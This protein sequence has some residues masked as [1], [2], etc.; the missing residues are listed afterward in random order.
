MYRV[1]FIADSQLPKTTLEISSVLT[2]LR[3][4]SSPTAAGF[5]RCGWVSESISTQFNDFTYE[6]YRPWRRYE[7]VVFAKSF[8]GECIELALKLK[9]KDVKIIFDINVD[10]F[11]KPYG[12][13]YYQGMEP[14]PS[15]VTNARKMVLI[16]DGVIAASEH[17]AESCGS[18]TQLA[19]IPDNIDGNLLPKNPAKNVTV[20]GKIRFLWSGMPQKMVDL[21]LIED[22][23]LK[24]SSRFELVLVTRRLDLLERCF[25]PYKSRLKNLLEQLQPKVID[26]ESI[27]QLL[28]VYSEGGVFLSPRFMENSYNLGHS[29]W[30][31]TLPMS[32]GLPV[33]CSPLRSYS[34][35]ARRAEGGICI[36]NNITDWERNLGKLFQGELF[37]NYD[38]RSAVNLVNKYYL[39]SIVSKQH[40]SFVKGLCE[41]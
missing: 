40:Y 41:I 35:V 29:E 33:I 27:H 16:A 1:G 26:F 38:H 10:Y 30:K 36:C 12:S 17:I 28:G 14:S 11:T 18:E 15:Q 3:G 22:L 4:R 5:M 25:E 23:L 21:L 19:W 20:N 34:T 24:N 32:V 2:F 7:V 9:A 31:I 37:N 8:S 13:F 39:T 6:W